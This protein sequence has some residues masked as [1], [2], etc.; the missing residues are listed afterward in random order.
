MSWKMTKEWLRKVFGG[1]P[2][3]TPCLTST[4]AW[5]ERQKEKGQKAGLCWYYRHGVVRYSNYHCVGF[6]ESDGERTYIETQTG[7]PVRLSE[8]ELATSTLEQAL[9]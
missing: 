6:T 3:Q 7:Q 9:K 5:L 8:K 4:L 1:P 2:D